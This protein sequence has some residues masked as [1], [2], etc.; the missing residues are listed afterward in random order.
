MH[1]YIQHK[2]LDTGSTYVF[3]LTEY[4]NVFNNLGSS[5]QDFGGEA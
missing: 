1:L 2:V 4:E 3:R 5:T